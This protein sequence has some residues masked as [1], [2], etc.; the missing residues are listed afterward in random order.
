[1]PTAKI[2]KRAV[3]GIGNAEKDQFLWDT[4]V[5]GFGC[6]VTAK[7]SR[8]Y[9]VQYRM[10][11]R[12]TNAVRYT[13]GKH[14]VWTPDTAREEARRLLRLADQGLD[15]REEERKRRR[16]AVELAFPAY[17]ELFVELYLQKNWKAWKDGQQHLDKHC[18][19]YLKTKPIS[20]IRKQD[21]TL[22]LDK[23]AERPAL[24]KN[25]FAT[26]R[27]MFNWAVN[28][29]DIEASP[30][31]GMT[32]P[33]G[34]K[35]RERVL[36]N[37]E[38]V[39]VWHA[40]GELD[41]RHGSVVRLLM[42]NG[43]RLEEDAGMQWPELDL[44]KRQWTIPGSRTKNELPQVVPLGPSSLSIIEERQRTPS[45]FVFVGARG[46]SPGSWTTVKEQLDGIVLRILQERAKARGDD[47]SH[48]QLTPW[49]LHDLRR[50]L[51]TGMPELGVAAEVVEAVLNHVSGAKAGVAGVYNRYAY[52]AEKT[53]ALLKWDEHVRAIIA[54]PNLP[55]EAPE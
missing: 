7:G 21:I 43:Q 12:E 42:L 52:L 51:A 10:G 28:R 14:G 17:A 48:V 47:P 34:V 22:V 27:K 46:R 19:P 26:L 33:S 40:A 15:P 32:P 25:V 37:E 53:A 8:S 49:R 29:G 9:V 30:L 36:R 41:D 3:D 23:L 50:T 4:E 18:A 45:P 5:P 16:E 13:I 11:G 44:G 6:K 20:A 39:A 24:S 2:T 55:P 1:M 38:L 35:A 54:A 31:T